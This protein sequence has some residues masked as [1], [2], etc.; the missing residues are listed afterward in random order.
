MGKQ[1]ITDKTIF[2]TVVYFSGK[3]AGPVPGPDQRTA[4][5]TRR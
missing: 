4:A 1:G 2:K 5:L 3:A